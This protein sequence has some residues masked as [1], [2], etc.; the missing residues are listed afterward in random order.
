MATKPT[1]FADHVQ[2]DN[3]GLTEQR[4]LIK[5]FF[6][7]PPTYQYAAFNYAALDRRDIARL[8]CGFGLLGFALLNAF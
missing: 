8:A 1:D 7:Q 2:L 4:V 3:A 6:R 5:Q